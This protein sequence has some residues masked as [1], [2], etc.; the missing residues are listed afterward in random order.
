MFSNESSILIQS[1][2]LKDKKEIVDE[3]DSDDL[4]IYDD[5]ENSDLLK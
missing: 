2:D 4:M 3:N 5:E 1:F